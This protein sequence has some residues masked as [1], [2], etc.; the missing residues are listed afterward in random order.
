MLTE[1]FFDFKRNAGDGLCWVKGCRRSSRHDRSLCHMHEMRRWR[2]KY[3]KTADYCTLRDHARERGIEFKITLD[4]WK[5]LTDAFGYYEKRDDQ[6]LSIDR[7]VASKG[8]IEG[9]VRVITLALNAHKGNKEK[10]LPEHVQNM[11]ERRRGQL[12]TENKKHLDMKPVEDLLDIYAEGGPPAD[13]NQ[14]F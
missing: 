9:N 6:I 14:P 13:P 2:A 3:N 12:Q 10:H 7:V 8:Y 1:G 11:L 4:Y 5:G